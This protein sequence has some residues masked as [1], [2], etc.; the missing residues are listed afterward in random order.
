MKVIIID[1]TVQTNEP[2]LVSK[3]RPV[4]EAKNQAKK[5]LRRL[6]E[7]LTPKGTAFVVITFLCLVWADKW[8]YV[9]WPLT[10]ICAIL[11]IKYFRSRPAV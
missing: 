11:T 3:E 4:V 7:W 8:P 6:Y 1:D 2:K 9:F 5:P 10:V